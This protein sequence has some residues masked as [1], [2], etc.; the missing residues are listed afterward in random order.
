MGSIVSYDVLTLFRQHVNL[1]TFATIGSPLAMPVVVGK[2]AGELKLRRPIGRHLKTPLKVGYHWY[3]FSDLEDKVAFSYH[4]RHEYDENEN[5]IEVIDYEV[6]ND[7]EM[8]GKKNP[9]K[10][11]GYLR[12]PEFSNVLYRFISRKPETV[13]RKIIS[14]IGRL[15]GRVKESEENLD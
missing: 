12:T 3:N 7:Y 2:I 8:K 9:H 1:H 13:Y 11:Y 10:S 14:L 6:H 15:Y 4:L 5:G